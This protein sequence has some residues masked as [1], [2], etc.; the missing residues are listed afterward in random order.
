MSRT[1]T[2]ETGPT[3]P[4]T[5]TKRP[6]AVNSLPPSRPFAVSSTRS[7]PTPTPTPTGNLSASTSAHPSA[8]TCS[9]EC[10]DRDFIWGRGGLVLVG[11]LDCCFYFSSIRWGSF[12]GHGFWLVAWGGSGWVWFGSSF[13]PGPWG[14]RSGTCECK[15]V[16]LTLD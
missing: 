10:S 3:K 13:V 1:R 12:L 5:P 16:R 11:G 7:S 2:G 8:M 15:H 4:C 14:S 9:V 6:P